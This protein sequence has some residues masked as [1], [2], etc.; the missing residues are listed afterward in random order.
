MPN[1]AGRPTNPPDTETATAALMRQN[2]RNRADYNA[3][4][5]TPAER[6]VALDNALAAAQGVAEIIMI[7]PND[8]TKKR[9]E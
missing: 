6:A 3:K 1:A 8:P 2:A 4:W 5:L 7:A 9:N